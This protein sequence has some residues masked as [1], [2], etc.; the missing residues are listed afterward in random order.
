MPSRM[1]W[2]CSAVPMAAK[3]WLFLV[4]DLFVEDLAIDPV[5]PNRIYS[6]GPEHSGGWLSRS[7]DEGNTWIPITTT[8]PISQTSGRNDCQAKYRL[9]S[10]SGVVYASAC[11]AD[12]GESGLIKSEDYGD[13][14]E[15]LMDGITDTQVTELAFHP[16]NPLTMYLGTASG[17]IFIS[18]NGGQAW[19]FASK[20]LENV[21]EIAVS[22]FGP[23]KVWIATGWQWLGDPCGVLKSTNA[24]LTAW[25]PIHDIGD[26]HIVIPP[27]IWGE[28]YS[29]TVFMATGEDDNVKKLMAAIPG[30]ILD[31]GWGN[32]SGC[33]SNKPKHHLRGRWRWF[34]QDHRRGRVLGIC[35]SRFNGYQTLVIGNRARS[36]RDRIR[37]N[38]YL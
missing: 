35:Q 10:V 15:P 27:G 11:G 36:T 6:V 26:A 37:P 21:Y 23:N 22:P 38:Q 12:G 32:R 16:T 20:P 4:A 9:Y 17:N 24:G 33:A 30:S 14:W 31:Q 13:T 18:H 3:T 19:A 2:G 28:V 1:T 34:L 25:T 5:S 8:F 7:D 29:D